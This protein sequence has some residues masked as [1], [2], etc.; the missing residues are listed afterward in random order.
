MI[1][2]K[3]LGKGHK[4][5]FALNSSV[6]SVCF[7]QNL[8][9]LHDSLGSDMIFCA[10]TTLCLLTI[11]IRAK[12]NCV[13]QLRYQKREKAVSLLKKRKIGVSCGP[14]RYVRLP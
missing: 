3:H 4:I 9:C 5:T 10:Q 13:A 2:W 7:S 14:N 12:D 6:S 11:L 8:Y 1:F